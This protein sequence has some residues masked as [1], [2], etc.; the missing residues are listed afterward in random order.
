M[1]NRARFL[2]YPL[3]DIEALIVRV[4]LSKI[5]TENGSCC[6]PMDHGSV[7]PLPWNLGWREA[8]GSYGGLNAH[9]SYHNRCSVGDHRASELH[10]DGESVVRREVDVGLSRGLAHTRDHA[11][12]ERAGAPLVG[13][14]SSFRVRA[15]VFIG[16]TPLRDPSGSESIASRRD[17]RNPSGIL[18]T[19]RNRICR[20]WNPF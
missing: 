10:L 15:L 8:I 6:S 17:H 11:L 5:C 16:T 20:F 4:G 1:V 12:P 18:E 14:T 13:G 7:H 19:G 2:G 3:S 9:R